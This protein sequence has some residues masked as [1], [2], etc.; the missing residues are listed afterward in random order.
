MMEPSA[1]DMDY[2]GNIFVADAGNSRIQ[3]FTPDGRLLDEFGGIGF[4][5][6]SMSWP[7]DV[8]CD[9]SFYVYVVDWG[10][11]RVLKFKERFDFTS[12]FLTVFSSGRELVEPEKIAVSDAGNLYITDLSNDYVVSLD[13]FGEFETY[14]GEFGSTPADISVSDGRLHF[15]DRASR[16]IVVYDLFGGELARYPM[17]EAEEPVSI[18]IDSHGNAYVADR[19]GGKVLVYGPQGALLSLIDSW[20][21][22]KFASPSSVSVGD[23]RLVITDSSQSLVY[24]FETDKE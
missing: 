9:Q 3:V 10:N 12:Y 14:I 1:C 4:G 7:T 6:G 22:R 23:S 2:R 16:S 11:K 18:D 17:R 24:V 5:E 13:S 21:D 15:L 8:F 19:T 20:R